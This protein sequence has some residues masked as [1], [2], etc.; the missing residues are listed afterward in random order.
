LN[1]SLIIHEITISRFSVFAWLDV[2]VTAVVVILKI[3]EEKD[4]FSKWMF[5]VTATLLV[6][7]S[8]GLPLFLYLRE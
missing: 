5:P 1:I 2:I 3:I 7:P 8:C 4:K 6:G